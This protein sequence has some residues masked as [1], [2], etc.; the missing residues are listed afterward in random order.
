MPFICSS[1]M[2]CSFLP[3]PNNSLVG[4]LGSD[5]LRSD[6]A[7]ECNFEF[8]DLGGGEMVKTCETIFFAQRR[9]TQRYKN[10]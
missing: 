3:V 8:I 6:N 4:V 2:L 7:Q 9:R 1:K 10:A 5:V